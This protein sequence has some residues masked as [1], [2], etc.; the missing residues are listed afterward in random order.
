MSPVRFATFMCAL[1]ILGWALPAFGDTGTTRCARAG[2]K[3]ITA[4]AYAEAYTLRGTAYACR[5]ATHRTYR[6]G[7]VPYG[8]AGTDVV[9]ANVRLAGRRVAYTYTYSQQEV[10]IAVR[11]RDLQSGRLQH[12]V[13]AAGT[14]GVPSRFYGRLTALEL[15][16]NGDPAWIVQAPLTRPTDRVLVAL[17]RG[18][19]IVVDRGLSIDPK[20]LQ[21][22]SR[23]VRW[24]S[25][26]KPRSATVG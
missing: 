10:E 25:A 5:R 14:F 9:V 6:L 15:T 2:S 11:V 26:G 24:V 16:T 4:S 3:V 21:F 22:R 8:D 12:N 1:P 18:K 20:N 7:P 23:T 17:I 19:R 13:D